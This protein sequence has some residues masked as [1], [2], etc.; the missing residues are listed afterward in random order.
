MVRL[1]DH[2]VSKEGGTEEAEEAAREIQSLERF[3][4]AEG[5]RGRDARSNGK[6]ERGAKD[7]EVAKTLDEVRSESNRSNSAALLVASPFRILIR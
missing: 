2:V 5:K 6:R 1:L 7:G 3:L 4:L